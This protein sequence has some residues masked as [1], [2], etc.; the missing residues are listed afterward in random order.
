MPSD[1]SLPLA[2]NRRR[3][4]RVRAEETV[5]TLGVVLDISASGMRVRCEGKPPLKSG[6]LVTITLATPLGLLAMDVGVAWARRIG[7]G[8]GEIG[9]VFANIT[10]D[11]TKGVLSVLHGSQVGLVEWGKDNQGGGGSGK[12]AA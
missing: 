4:G 5:C 1:D 6:Q 3:H 9:L 10:E 7:W 2:E 8:S 12:R 11:V